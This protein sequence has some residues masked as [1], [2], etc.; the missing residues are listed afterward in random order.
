V[1]ASHV[2]IL[3]EQYITDMGKVK[4]GE[5][6]SALFSGTTCCFVNVMIEKTSFHRMCRRDFLAEKSGRNLT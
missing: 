2:I 5:S 1:F 4:R 3:V 6:L